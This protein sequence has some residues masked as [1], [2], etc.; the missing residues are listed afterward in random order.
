MN[1]DHVASGEPN[2]LSYYDSSGYSANKSFC[3]GKP[4]PRLEEECEAPC[5]VD[6]ELGRPGE[7][8]LC[9]KTC[10]RDSVRYRRRPVLQL[11]AH[12]GIPCP[13]ESLETGFVTETKR[14]RKATKCHSYEWSVGNWSACQL[15][16]AECGYGYKTRAVACF[17]NEHRKVTPG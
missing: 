3:E 13:K 10:G 6:C 11:G 8:S 2:L 15:T 4:R 5:P 14:C 17:R 12:G 1:F 7:W 9:T 16:T